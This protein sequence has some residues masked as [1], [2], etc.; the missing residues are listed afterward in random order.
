MST[1][2]RLM[3]SVGFRAVH[4]LA[5][6]G[7]DDAA[8]RQR[9][10]WTAWPHSHE[11]RCTV[12]VAGPVTDDLAMVV[13]LPTLDAILRVEVVDRFEGRHLHRD[14]PELAAIPTTCEALARLIFSRVA[15]QLPA[16]SRLVSVRVAE[17]DTLAAEIVAQ[18]P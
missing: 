10:G 17:D 15:P 11:Y 6:P 2:V 5:L 13:D 14:I 16:P 4:R 3:R 7:A 1:Q 18:D 8:N 12:T 9:F